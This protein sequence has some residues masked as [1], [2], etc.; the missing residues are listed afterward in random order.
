[1][2][3]ARAI[4][5]SDS[6]TTP[7]LPFAPP[8]L[9]PYD[10]AVGVGSSND[11]DASSEMGRPDVGGRNCEGTGSVS[12]SCEAFFDRP[13]PELFARR[14]VLDDDEARSEFGDDPSVLVP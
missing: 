5:A 13:E 2:S 7:V 1:K 12:E 4:D 3:P 14:D 6:R 10:D 8:W 9:L 11:E